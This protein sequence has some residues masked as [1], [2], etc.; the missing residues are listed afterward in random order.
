MILF[1]LK[2]SSIFRLIMTFDSFLSLCHL[3]LRLSLKIFGDFDVPLDMVNAKFTLA[4]QLGTTL[5]S[6]FLQL[7]EFISE[8]V[9]VA[10]LSNDLS[11]LIIDIV[12]ERTCLFLLHNL[13]LD[14]RLATILL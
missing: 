4:R 10:W 6:F 7:L 12:L 2:F 5:H 3:L 13:L 1:F 14:N 11:Y 8:I 9:V